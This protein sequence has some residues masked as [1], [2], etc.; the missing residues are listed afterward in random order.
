MHHILRSTVLHGTEKWWLLFRFESQNIAV[1]GNKGNNV[2]INTVYRTFSLLFNLDKFLNQIYI[3]S[4][5]FSSGKQYHHFYFILIKIYI[6][7]NCTQ[8]YPPTHTRASAHSLP[9]LHSK[10]IPLNPD[11]CAYTFRQ[12]SFWDPQAT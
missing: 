8:S 5:V 6:I 1:N 2:N 4:N 12:C 11:Q 10:N 9:I 3:I 7:H